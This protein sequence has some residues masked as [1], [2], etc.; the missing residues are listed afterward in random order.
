M[1][2]KQHLNPFIAKLKIWSILFNNLGDFAPD[3]DGVN[4]L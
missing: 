3:T 2:I 1:A 4:M